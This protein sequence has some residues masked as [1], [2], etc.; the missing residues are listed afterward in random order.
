MLINYSTL[1]IINLITSY[2][3]VYNVTNL[4]FFAIIFRL[5][6]F[7]S[8]TFYSFNSLTPTSSLAKL[9]SLTLLS[10]AG[11]PPFTGF[12]T[13]IVVLSI[14][15]NSNFSILFITFFLL[16]FT[17]LYFYIQNIRFIQSKNKQILNNLILNNPQID[18]LTSVYCLLIALFVL[19][20]FMFLDDLSIQLNVIFVK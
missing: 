18:L 20:G 4:L 12:F 14:L 19:T 16:I 9:L 15:S 17:G 5:S 11:V 10:M 2:L 8:K 3:I 6:T 1:E 13:K 7:S